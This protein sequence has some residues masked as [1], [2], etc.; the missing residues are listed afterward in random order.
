[1][2]K[3]LSEYFSANPQVKQLLLVGAITHLLTAFT[4][5]IVGYFQ[6]F[7]SQISNSGI[8]SGDSVLYLQKCQELSARIQNGDLSFFFTN[9]FDL[10]L[11]IYALSYFVF[12][13]I[14]G[15]SIFCFEPINIV[16]FLI[17]LFLVYKIGELCFN[18]KVGF[19]SALIINF[20]PTFLLHSVQPLRDPLYVCLF[21]ALI[22]C[23]LTIIYENPYFK[24][25]LRLLIFSYVI[26]FSLWIVRDNAFPVFLTVALIS[27][28]LFLVRTWSIYKSRL[29]QISLFGIFII[30]IFLMPPLFSSLQPKS[31]LTSEMSVEKKEK[32]HNFSQKQIEKG[33]PQS[34]RYLNGIR[35]GINL[36]IEVEDG[37]AAMDRNLVFESWSDVVF[38]SPK[39]VLIGIF[40]PFPNMWFEDGKMFGKTGRIIAAF[41]VVIIYILSAFA[42][43]T[44]YYQRKNLGLWLIGLTVLIGCGALGLVVTNIG[45]LYRM[46]YV[47]WGLLII[48][49]TGGIFKLIEL[50]RLTL[51]HNIGSLNKNMKL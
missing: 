23:L 37:S 32:S 49:G 33:V 38:Y 19:L 44:F 30:S 3:R 17:L 1:M 31:I 12:S 15:N 46:R 36:Q 26:I 10:H 13:N 40:S 34:V 14:F 9:D 35:R 51:L 45:T 20:S 48:L 50:K 47:F 11:R 41:E 18:S 16:L 24:K 29:S 42:L 2:S 7:P 8:L 27:F 25:L 28:V 4:V 39:A 43:L 5:S 21:L 22:Y 6:F